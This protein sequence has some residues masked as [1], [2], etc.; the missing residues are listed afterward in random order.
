MGA[1]RARLAWR[2]YPNGQAITATSQAGNMVASRLLGTS[3]QLPWR[4]TSTAA[5][6][7]SGTF[8]DL[9]SCNYL[10][11][12]AHNLSYGATMRLQLSLDA[13]FSSPTY[14]N[15]WDAVLPAYGFGVDSF[16]IEPF[17]GYTPNK[18]TP[19]S[20]FWFDNSLAQF[21]RVTI[22]DTGNPDGY[23]QAG[24]LMLGDYWDC[25]DVRSNILYGYKRGVDNLAKL[26]RSYSGEV[27]VD[28]NKPYRKFSL[29]FGTLTE[30]DEQNLYDMV[31]TC[32]L[33]GHV[34][35]SAY[36]ESDTTEGNAHTSLC[37]IVSSSESTRANFIWREQSFVLEEVI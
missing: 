26:Q 34:L 35:F 10:C 14:D 33:N 9:K 20:V 30:N 31:T 7:L 5:Q 8:A 1:Q 4:S 12:Y 17:G 13:S 32:G 29:G 36:P 24:R 18:Q 2:S 25:E 37:R 22:T 15:T 6:V 3:I 27:Y 23:I 16:G 11:L 19:Y 21:W 28:R